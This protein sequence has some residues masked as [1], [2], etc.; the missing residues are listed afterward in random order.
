MFE[1][2]DLHDPEL[3]A[4]LT[5]R[6]VA[7]PSSPWPQ[8]GGHP[9]RL[10]GASLEFSEHTEYTPGDDIKSLDWRLYAKTDRYYVKRYEDERLSRAMIVVDGSESMTYGGGEDM[11]GS[12]FQLS[13]K[14]AVALASALVRQGDAAGLALLGPAPVYLAP[15]PGAQQVEVILEVL[16]NAKVGGS[17]PVTPGCVEAAQR[18]GSSGTFVV[19]SDFLHIEDEGLEFLA[20]LAAR[21]V[22][23]RLVD[24]LHP[25]ET[26]LP[27]DKPLKFVDIE[28][29]ADLVIDPD[30]VRK[31]YVAEIRAHLAA[32]REK[33]T[34]FGAGFTLVTTQGEAV[35]RLPAFFSG[36]AKTGE[37][38][39]G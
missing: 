9:S 30:G 3:A 32:L 18:L 13:A 5:R 24:V 31:A 1:R 27:F 29:S 35:G 21:G 33:A 2:A 12:K 22:N 7:G 14:I 38:W 34:G 26:A 25:D 10:R 16:Q 37:R 20:G 6:G 15:R 39:T 8:R 11:R 36:F 23:A 19:I 4:A 28:T 17:A